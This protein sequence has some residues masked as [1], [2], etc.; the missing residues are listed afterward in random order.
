M[1]KVDSSKNEGRKDGAAVV[2]TSGSRIEKIEENNIHRMNDTAVSRILTI[3][4]KKAV[5][6]EH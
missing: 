5:I 2:A 6:A 1:W 3:D 4:K